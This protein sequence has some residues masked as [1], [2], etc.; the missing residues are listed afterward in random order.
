MALGQLQDRVAATADDVFRKQVGTSVGELSAAAAE[1]LNWAGGHTGYSA[2]K[3]LWINHPFSAVH[4][5]GEVSLG[6]IN[7]RL[8]EIPYAFAAA[9]KIPPGSHILDCGCC[10]NWV[11][12]ALA[13]FGYRV[14]GIDVRPYPIQVPNFTFVQEALEAWDGP[15]EPVDAILCLSSI[16]HLGLGAYGGPKSGERM[17]RVLLAKMR[18]WLKPSGLLIFTA[19]YGTWSID[20][21]QRVYNSSA[22]KDLLSGWEVQEARYYYTN[23][24]ATWKSGDESLDTHPFQDSGRAVVM[25]QARRTA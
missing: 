17:D 13:Q 11:A 18:G 12:P 2:Q 21:F 3:H 16:E 14:T 23:D 6:Y 19:P 9:L 24:G 22:L 1:F 10:E 20:D 5:K 15:R 4:A 7:E 25:L 8:L